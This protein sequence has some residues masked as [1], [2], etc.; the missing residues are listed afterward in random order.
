MTALDDRGSGCLAGLFLIVLAVA[1]TAILAW[2]VKG[3]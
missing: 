3:S 1:I 2:L